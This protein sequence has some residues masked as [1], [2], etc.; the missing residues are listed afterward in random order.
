MLTSTSD[1]TNSNRALNMH[2]TQ[3]TDKPNYVHIHSICNNGK[4]LVSYHLHRRSHDNSTTFITG[5]MTTLPPSS[6]V[7]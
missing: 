4:S 5:L 7:S 3:L 6:Q 2:T 1:A